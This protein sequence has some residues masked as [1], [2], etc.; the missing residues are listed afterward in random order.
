MGKLD[1]ET[2]ASLKAEI[3][4]YLNKIQLSNC[5][6]DAR[7]ERSFVKT[8]ITLGESGILKDYIDKHNLCR[9]AESELIASENLE[10][11]KFYIGKRKLSEDTQVNLV[12]TGKKEL[13]L[14]YLKKHRLCTRAWQYWRVKNS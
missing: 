8:C 6:L 12:A 5:Q 7:E 4:G 3:G 2:L 1:D 9:D 13:L 11:I 14:F 10:I